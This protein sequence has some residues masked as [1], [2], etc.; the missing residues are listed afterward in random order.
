ME[1]V[2]S[3]LLFQNAIRSNGCI[4]RED[5]ST[6]CRNLRINSDPSLQQS[7]D[8]NNSCSSCAHCLRLPMEEEPHVKLRGV[9]DELKEGYKPDLKEEEN[10]HYFQ[11]N[12]LLF[13]AHVQRTERIVTKFP[14]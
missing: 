2:Y 11:I 7:H 14:D 10:P 1:S 4:H 13:H 3:L 5:I 8:P 9:L 12:H 6:Q